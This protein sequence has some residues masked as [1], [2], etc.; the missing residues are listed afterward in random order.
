LAKDAL[1]QYLTTLATYQDEYDGDR[2]ILADAFGC[3]DGL[4]SEFCQA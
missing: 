2:L 1:G 4:F 3:N